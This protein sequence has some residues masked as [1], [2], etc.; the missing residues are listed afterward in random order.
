MPIRTYRHASIR[1]SIF[2]IIS[3]LTL[4]IFICCGLGVGYYTRFTAHAIFLESLPITWARSEERAIIQ[5]YESVGCSFLVLGT[6]VWCVCVCV[7]VW[8]PWPGCCYFQRITGLLTWGALSDKRMDPYFE[9]AAGPRQ[10]SHSLFRVPRRFEIPP[11]SNSQVPSF[12]PPRTRMSQSYREGISRHHL[13]LAGP[14]WRAR[15]TLKKVGEQ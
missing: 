11:T 7:C 2:M 6:R 5:S 3:V 14:H 9:I 8:G 13:R 15:V 1:I 4:Y 10:R 12:T